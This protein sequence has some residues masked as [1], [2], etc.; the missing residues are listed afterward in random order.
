MRIEITSP[1]DNFLIRPVDEGFTS[2]SD[3]VAKAYVGGK[4][5]R[6]VHIA[7]SA[8]LRKLRPGRGRAD[9][10]RPAIQ[11]AGLAPKESDD[12]YLELLRNDGAK[13]RGL[14]KALLRLRG[15]LRHQWR[16]GKVPK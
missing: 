2:H 7:G 14:T 8:M 15:Y 3:M 13:K 11:N 4:H 10:L 1:F 5:Y 6:F 16:Y 9:F 12:L